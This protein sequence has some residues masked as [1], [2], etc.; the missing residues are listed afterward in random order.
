M[1]FHETMKCLSI[2]WRHKWE[3]LCCTLLSV[4][5]VLLFSTGTSPLFA[6]EWEPRHI[7]SSIFQMLGVAILNGK[8]PYVDIFDHKGCILFFINALGYLINGKAGLLCLQMFNLAAT[9]MIWLRTTALFT[10]SHWRQWLSLLLTLWLL[11]FTF[12][13]G[14]LSEEWSLPWISLPLYYYFRYRYVQ[15][16]DIPTSRLFIIGIASGI[17]AFIRANN[18]APV[19]GILLWLLFDYARLQRWR[20][21]VRSIVVVTIGFLLPILASSLWFY[22]K[23]G[24]TGL[25]GLWYGTFIFNLEYMK[26]ATP[27][28]GS[29][30]LAT[31][32][33]LASLL[34]LPCLILWRRHWQMLPL[35]MAFVITLLA[36]GR[37]IYYHYLTIYAPLWVIAIAVILRSQWRTYVLSAV[38]LFLL[39]D[40]GGKVWRTLRHAQEDPAP[41]LAF[42]QEFCD[43][44]RSIPESERD[45]LWNYN[46]THV[47][48]D[49]LN[50]L[51]L[52]QSN[53]ILFRYHLHISDRMAAH[54]HA[55][56]RESPRWVLV[57]DS[58]FIRPDDQQF[59]D[60]HYSRYAAT[61]QGQVN[62]TF[63]HRK[64]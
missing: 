38:L 39:P 10:A 52:T 20:Y 31:L 37:V 25:D 53:L 13:D 1:F 16:E 2:L 41:Y 59:L 40:I 15:H 42:K 6:G 51:H 47:C 63:Y 17:I 62:V 32:L 4:A 23:A 26:N 57:A 46:A 22:A 50:D 18:A 5:F 33:R 9:L 8:V 24:L 21:I 61:R 35:L 12:E 54:K 3:M 19:L 14:N 56:Q 7:D 27:T 58:H 43:I 11:T 55:L 28:E 30:E 44:V 45:S 60:A 29:T 34:L 64:D 48:A 36:T 49:C